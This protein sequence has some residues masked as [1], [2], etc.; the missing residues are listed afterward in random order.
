MAFVRCIFCWNFEVPSG[1]RCESHSHPCTEIVF[2][3]KAAGQLLQG[4]TTYQYQDQTVLV[5]Q[6]GETHW[7]E[8]E[9][10]G[11]QICLGVIGGVCRD[12][13]AGVHKAGPELCQ[14][15]EEIVATLEK[16]NATCESRLDLLA[17]LVICELLDSGGAQR[18]TATPKAAERIRASIDRSLTENLSL[19][20]LAKRT[21]LS[22]EYLRKTFREEFDEP[23][24]KYI[25]RRR[26]ELACQLLLSGDDLVKE[27]AQQ[28]GFPDEFYFSR[29]FKN[30][31]G[32]SPSQFRKAAEN[33]TNGVVG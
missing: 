28:C 22:A 27:V 31:F 29:A 33:A 24:T 1:F 17:G 13:E 5:Y 25:L 12:L 9:I 7:V 4:G 16:R 18:K 23:I 3:S 26:L 11:R 32:K 2:N 19:K 15:F 30:A 21:Y 6:P 10:P 14:R 8:N 20:E